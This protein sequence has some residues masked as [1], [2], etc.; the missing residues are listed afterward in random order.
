M[1]TARTLVD[2]KLII[3]PKRGMTDVNTGKKYVE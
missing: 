1:K 2:T 3:R